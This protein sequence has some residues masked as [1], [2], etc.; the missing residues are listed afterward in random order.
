MNESDKKNNVKNSQSVM[1]DLF[2]AIVG[3]VVVDSN[4]NYESISV[5]CEAMLNLS[6]FD[7]NYIKWINNWCAEN[8]YQLYFRPILNFSFPNYLNGP[9]FGPNMLN[10]YTGQM[11]FSHNKPSSLSSMV[12]GA[13]LVIH[14]AKINVQSD[15]QGEYTAYMDCAEKAYRI[16]QSRAMKESIDK[17]DISTAVNQL[18]ILYQK[19]FI[20]EP[21][22][23]FDEQHDDD[24]NP[25]W[26]C[27]CYVDEL[28]YYYVGKASIKKEAKKQAAYDALC[29]LLNEKGE[30]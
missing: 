24:G 15:I 22:Y 9:F 28:K 12:N 17:P 18:N 29:A 20:S 27:K 1:A 4:W 23:L 10:P 11:E 8:G 14:E 30:D 6:N 16:I 13:Y 19:E 25:I 7:M 2:E 21:E 3:A 26:E 5:V